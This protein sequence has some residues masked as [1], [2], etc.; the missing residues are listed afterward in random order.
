MRIFISRQFF[1]FLLT[2]GIAA[3]VNFASR[4][5]YNRLVGFSAAVTFAYLTGMVTAFILAK[6][7]VFQES[8]H[9]TFRSAVL[10]TAVNIFAFSQTWIVSMVLAYHI[11]PALGVRTFGKD[12]ASFVGIVVPVFS[13]FLA[14][15]HISF[16]ARSTSP[17]QQHN[18]QTVSLYIPKHD[19]QGY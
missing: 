8:S 15:K 11:L 4:I 14:H 16:R 6:F 1:T 5:L 18:Q 13:S 2:G 9:S 3:V 10:F 19:D 17:P 7:F 12:I